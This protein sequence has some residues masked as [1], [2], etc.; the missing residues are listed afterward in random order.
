MRGLCQGHYAGWRSSYPCDEGD[1]T[2]R[3]YSKGLCYKHFWLLDAWRES[4]PT[5]FLPDAPEET[6]TTM[7]PTIVHTLCGEDGCDRRALSKGLCKRHYYVTWMKAQH[8]LIEGCTENYAARGG[9]WRHYN[10]VMDE[11]VEHVRDLASPVAPTMFKHRRARSTAKPV[12][13]IPE[14]VVV[15]TR[16]SVSAPAASRGRVQFRRSSV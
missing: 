9:C 7:T 6:A 12:V 2:G 10:Q 3:H 5:R 15:V 4:F 13:S 14:P 1:C 8:C 16:P 11:G